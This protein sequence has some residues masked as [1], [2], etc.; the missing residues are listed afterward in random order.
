MN[1]MNLVKKRYSILISEH[2]SEGQSLL[3]LAIAEINSEIEVNLVFT[4]EQLIQYL[5]LGKVERELNRQD[6]PNFVIASLNE[7]FFTEQSLRDIRQYE[8]LYALPV[9]VL[10]SDFSED[11]KE[12]LQT[13]GAN[14]VLKK[15]DTLEA[16][17]ELLEKIISTHQPKRLTKA[18]FCSRC[19]E[20]MEFDP[21]WGPLAGQIKI[22]LKESEF[23]KERFDGPFCVPCLR[24][25]QN[26]YR[27]ISGNDGNGARGIITY[28]QQ[29]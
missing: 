20:Y 13:A 23:I 17:K 7:P 18:L 1:F 29:N 26:S 27:I 24:Q 9:Y 6:F 19:E 3:K 22:S 11:L 25:L 12:R 16:M 21:N 4:G 14:E 28:K 5:L 15:P 10:V 2:D 8:K